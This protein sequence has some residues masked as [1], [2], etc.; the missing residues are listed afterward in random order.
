MMKT[1]RPDTAQAELTTGRKIATLDLQV[2]TLS[3]SGEAILQVVWTLR[4]RSESGQCRR[5]PSELRV[6]YNR[7][8]MCGLRGL[9][10][11]EQLR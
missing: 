10:L 8:V 7:S 3:T 1:L 5:L 4:F 9:G 2:L 6:D 11:G